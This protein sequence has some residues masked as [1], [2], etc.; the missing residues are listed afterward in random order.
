MARGG[1]P[2]VNGGSNA[3]ALNRRLARTMMAGNQQNEP[4]ATRDCLL[5]PPVDGSPGSIEIHSVKIEHPVGLDGS[6]AQSFVPASIKG[7][8]AV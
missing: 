1:Q 4:V 6:V 5:D 2:V 7:S 8:H 3:P